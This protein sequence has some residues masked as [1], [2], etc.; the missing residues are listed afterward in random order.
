MLREGRE[1][2]VQVS[3]LQ[4]SRGGGG[5]RLTQVPT[6]SSAWPASE[7]AGDYAATLDHGKDA[8]VAAVEEMEEEEVEKGE[9][10]AARLVE[11]IVPAPDVEDTG[12]RLN[13]RGARPCQCRPGCSVR[14]ESSS[15]A[16]STSGDGRAQPWILCY[17]RGWIVIC[18]SK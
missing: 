1:G 7:P 14:R 2:E 10:E 15:T 17:G 16:T 8:W 5:P 3:S 13:G 9:E 12:P 6:V 4:G 18:T 11:A